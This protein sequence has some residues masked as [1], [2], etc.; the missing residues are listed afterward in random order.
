MF[1]SKEAY[2]EFYTGRGKRNSTFLLLCKNIVRVKQKL[3]GTF[4]SENERGAFFY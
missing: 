3:E 4:F 2:V 1:K